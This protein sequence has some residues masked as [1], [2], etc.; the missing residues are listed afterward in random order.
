M[1]NCLRFPSLQA[2]FYHVW[3]ASKDLRS[4]PQCRC[5]RSHHQSSRYQRNIHLRKADVHLLRVFI[6]LWW[7]IGPHSWIVHSFDYFKLG[8][9]F[10]SRVSRS[11]GKRFFLVDFEPRFSDI[12]EGLMGIKTKIMMHGKHKSGY[13]HQSIQTQD[14][15]PEN[16]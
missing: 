16:T 13:R 6:R 10:Q 14:R 4:L 11:I 12:F 2:R 3:K 8:D 1:R 5:C 7:S 9:D 15:L